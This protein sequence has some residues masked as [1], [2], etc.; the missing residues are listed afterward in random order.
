MTQFV[1]VLLPISAIKCVDFQG[2]HGPG[3]QTPC[4][5]AISLGIGSRYVERLDATHRAEI[6][7]G[8]AGIELIVCRVVVT[9]AQREVFLAHD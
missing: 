8:N 9:T 4:I 6:M 2:L 7:L 1:S 5:D 3:I